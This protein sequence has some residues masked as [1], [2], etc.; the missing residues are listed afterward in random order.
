MHEPLPDTPLDIVGDVH[1]ELDA[2]RS[3]LEVA[4]YDGQGR[5]P[6]G[7][8]LVFVG[9]LVDRGPDSPG[10]VRLVRDLVEAG[11]AQVI[12]GNHE[13]NLLRGERKY[14][15]DWFWNERSPRDAKLAPYAALPTESDRRELL[16]FFAGLPLIL[17]RP[18]LR[19]VHAAWHAPSVEAL[20][21]N[22][23]RGGIGERFRDFETAAEANLQSNGWLERAAEE[24][25][26]WDLHR[27][28]PKVPHLP[29]TAHCDE[30]RQMANPIR[31]LTSGIERMVNRP[32]F[33]SGRWRFAERVSWWDEYK[34]EVPVV[35]GHYWRQYLPLDRISLGKG[36][37]DLF[38][39]LDPTAW[40]G[41][42]GNVF[43]VDYS[44]GGRY[45]ERLSGMSGLRTHLALLRWP[46]QELLLETGERRQTGGCSR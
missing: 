40:L 13:L 22:A 5:H 4:S 17:N 44:V 25:K 11:R 18:D 27:Q 32:F 41:P 42:A 2:L 37:P 46:E 31:V 28:E 38:E 7:R 30:Y 36:D 6:Q 16:E 3:L 10:V 43:C 12:L 26:T 34:D 14:G 15:N 19:V 23:A 35:V 29:A 33:S 9:D 21:T 20:A 39:G 8:S 45:R 1:G 24:A